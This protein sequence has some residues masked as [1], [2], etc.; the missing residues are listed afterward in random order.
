MFKGTMDLNILGALYDILLDLR[1]IIDIDSLKYDGQCSKLIHALAIFIILTRYAKFLVIALRCLQDNLLGL[2]VK[3]LLYL[4]MNV[5]N[6]CFEKSGHSVAIL[7]GI[8]SNNKVLTC[9]CWAEL[10][11][12]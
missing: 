4:L 12:L 9:Q 11:D 2:E 7:S 6:F 8:S 3:L 10:N 5:K 1:I